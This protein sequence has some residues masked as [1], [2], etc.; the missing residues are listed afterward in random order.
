MLDLLK[1]GAEAISRHGDKFKSLL[2]P[3][4]TDDFL[5]DIKSGRLF[6][7]Q[8][9]L[10]HFIG[11]AVE[12][13]DGVSLKETKF[14]SD[15]ILLVLSVRKFG[16]QI[17]CPLKLTIASFEINKQNQQ[18]VFEY[19]CDKAVGQNLAGRI[20]AAIASGLISRIIKEKISGVGGSTPIPPGHGNTVCVDLS[21]VEHVRALLKPIPKMKLCILDFF[22]LVGIEHVQDGLLLLGCMQIMPD[23]FGNKN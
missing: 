10:Q 20:A 3:Y 5:G 15:Y 16:S 14:T 9:A 21:D 13:E 22:N 8:D 4:L 12:K 18:I 19:T 23:L 2:N 11:K 7:P 1:K 17:D 6:I